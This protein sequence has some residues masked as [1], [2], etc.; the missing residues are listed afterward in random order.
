MYGTLFSFKGGQF[1]VFSIP[2]GSV[3]EIYLGCSTYKNISRLG[4]PEEEYAQIKSEWRTK[5]IS[6]FNVRQIKNN[7]QLES[8]VHN[9]S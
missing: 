7:W 8:Y 3:K 2:T 4:F 9:G 5:G 1:T 6:V